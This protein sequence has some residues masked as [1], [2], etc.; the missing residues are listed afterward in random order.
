MQ[1]LLSRLASK[2]RAAILADGVKDTGCGI[3]VFHRDTYLELPAFDHMHRF[4]PALMQRNGRRVCSMP[5]NHRARR[6]GVSKYG[7]N[8]RLWAGIV[9]LFGVMWLQ[10]RRL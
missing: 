5:V 7:V 4:L 3:K 10:K 8:D 2:V 9:D 6:S 1:R